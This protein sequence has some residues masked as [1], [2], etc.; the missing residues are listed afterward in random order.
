MGKPAEASKHVITETLLELKREGADQTAVTNRL[1]EIMFEEL[2]RIASSLMRS[3]RPDH[4]LQPTAL[5]NETYLRLVDD[6]RVDWQNR[7]HFFGIA[8][9][10]MRQVLMEHARRRAAA[11]RGGDWRRVTLS[12]DLGLK[13]SADVDLFELDSAMGKLAEMDP[14]S[15]QIVELRVFGGMHVNEVAHVLDISPRTVQNDWRVA[16]MWLTRELTG[17]RGS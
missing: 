17:Q 13:I 7:A 9:R 1:F 6:A 14:R 8:A 10:A 16:K 2:R 11:K 15:A 12:S 4:T 3:E 5:V